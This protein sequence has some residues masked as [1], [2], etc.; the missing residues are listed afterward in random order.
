MGI[1]LIY[2]YTEKNTFGK[3]NRNISNVK[4]EMLKSPS[5]WKFKKKFFFLVRMSFKGAKKVEQ[6]FIGFFL[7]GPRAQVAFKPKKPLEIPSE[8]SVDAILN[9]YRK[10]NTMKKAPA[11]YSILG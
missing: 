5:H 6:K 4:L 1:R 10:Q 7:L 9:E 2:I 8:L 11:F 3:S